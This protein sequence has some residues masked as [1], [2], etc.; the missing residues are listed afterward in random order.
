MYAES[1]I[2]AH[3]ALWGKGRETFL[4]AD[5]LFLRAQEGPD[6]GPRPLETDARD[7]LF[8]EYDDISSWYFICRLTEFFVFSGRCCRKKLSEKQRRKDNTCQREIFF[9]FS[10][11]SA[12]VKLLLIF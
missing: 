7:R 3:I 1:C 4:P 10:L 5:G 9:H 12:K 11:N 8:I 2:F 6:R